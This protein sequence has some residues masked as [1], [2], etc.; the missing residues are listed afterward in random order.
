MV[1]V[2]KSIPNFGT[3]TVSYGVLAQNFYEIALSLLLSPL[4]ILRSLETSLE[5]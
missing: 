2:P 3:T 5:G 1:K 4:E